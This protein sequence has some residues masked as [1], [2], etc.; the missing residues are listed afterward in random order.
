[1]RTTKTTNG[2]KVNAIAGTYVVMFGFDLPE[3]ECSGLLGFSIHRVDPAENEAGY[4]KAMK[5][6]TETDPGFPTGSLYS[7]RDHPIQSFQW[8]DYSAKPG[9][10]YTYTITANKGGAGESHAIRGDN[11]Q[12]HY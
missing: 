4:L 11:N 8:A 5:V 9:H 7:T 12:H 10:S 3:A 2:L 1:M 6:F